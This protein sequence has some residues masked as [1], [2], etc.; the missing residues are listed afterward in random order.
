M[1]N[2]DCKI[3]PLLEPQCSDC[4]S[5]KTCI[6]V[7]QSCNVCAYTSCLDNAQVSAG[8]YTIGSFGSPGPIS[9]INPISSTSLESQSVTQSTSASSF[10]TTIIG[11]SVAQTSSALVSSASSKMASTSSRASSMGGSAISSPTPGTAASIGHISIDIGGLLWT[12]I[13]FCIG[14]GIFGGRRWRL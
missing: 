13:A 10:S 11:S 3:C 12:L 7:L 1:A 2:I 14:T 6:I 4:G 9:T 8:H 5:G